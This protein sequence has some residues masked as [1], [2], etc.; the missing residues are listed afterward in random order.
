MADG[1]APRYRTSTKARDVLPATHTAPNDSSLKTPVRAG[2]SSKA[3]SYGTLTSS[4]QSRTAYG[5]SEDSHIPV[6]PENDKH[7]R[8]GRNDRTRR[9]N[10]QRSGA[11]AFLLQDGGGDLATGGRRSRATSHSKSKLQPLSPDQRQSHSSRDS[12]SK[13][14]SIDAS[15]KD[16]YPP[17]SRHS[18]THS[19][20]STTDSTKGEHSNESSPSNV[21][22]SL[23]ADSTQIIH[24][25]LNLSESRRMASR[26]SVSRANPPRLTPMPDSTRSNLKQH[27]Q[28]QRRASRTGSP[29]PKQGS[30]PRIPSGFKV[31][32]PHQSGVDG[33]NATSYRYHFS[34]STL[35]RAQKAK[36][37]LEL[38]ELYRQ[39]LEYLPPLKPGAGGASHT[40]PISDSPLSRTRTVIHDTGLG[41]TQKLG[42]PYDPLQYIRNRKVRARE[43]KV[44]DGEQLGFGDTEVVREW[45]NQL[46]HQN[47][48][49]GS[50]SSDQSFVMPPFARA[51]EAEEQTSS[52]VKAA[53]RVRRPRVDWFFDPCDMIA[54]AYWL[55]QDHHKHLIEDRAS[56]KIF[57]AIADSSRPGSQQ[58]NDI[59]PGSLISPTKFGERP[60]TSDHPGAHMDAADIIAGQV[61]SR[62]RA[63][64][65]LHDIRGLHHRH[66][67]SHS[68][69]DFLA[70]RDSLSEA[71]DSDS[72]GRRDK[73][74]KSR[75]LR[76]DTITSDAS[77]LL[78]KQMMNMVAQEEARET[79]GDLIEHPDEKSFD[80]AT[81]ENKQQSKV[82]SHSHSRENSIAGSSDAES[83][84]GTV[85]SRLGSSKPY[86]R[87]RASLEVPEDTRFGF[88][89]DVDTSAPTS[90]QLSA[91]GDQTAP[92]PLGLDQSAP[93]SRASSP[94]RNPLSKVKRKLRERGRDNGGESQS[95]AEDD[96]GQHTAL[97]ET[98]SPLDGQRSR[99]ESA[100]AR[101]KDDAVGLR[102]IFKGPRIDNV[103][104]GGVS[105]IGDIIW[106]KDVTSDSDS[107]SSSDSE[108]DVGPKERSSRPMLSRAGSKMSDVPP[109]AKHFYDAM[110]HFQPISE[111]ANKANG[112]THGQALAPPEL[113]RP[114]S[115]QSARWEQ[116]KPPRID[117][118]TATPSPSPSVAPSK[119]L[120]GSEVSESDSN[121]QSASDE[122]H[123][124]TH[125]LEESATR[126]SGISSGAVSTSHH[127]SITDRN[128]SPERTRL[129]KREVARLRALIL[130]S[131]VKAME[132]N[133]RA[134]EVRKP[135]GQRSNP[136]TKPDPR[137][138]VCTLDW[139]EMIELNPE[140]GGLRE[141]AVATCEVYPLASRALGMSIQA[142][143]Q[144]WQ[145][146]ADEFANKTVPALRQRV[147]QLRSR[148][149]DDLSGL[150]RK[151][152][153]EAD[154]TNKGLALDQPLKVKHVLDAMD[155]LLRQRRR[156]FRWVRRGMWLAVEWVLIGFMWYVWFV[157]MIFRLFLGVGRVTLK[158]VRW[159]LWL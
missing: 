2:E 145:S 120:G 149:G 112:T 42:R 113:S 31:N 140:C 3:T 41:A 98:T 125:E 151:A 80:P 22:T 155:T 118:N 28:Q 134:N 150:T 72:D 60:G 36:D 19:T 111:T 101:A 153:D 69:N 26:R 158:G 50:Q 18:G 67:S 91:R 135:L 87:G 92:P 62:E 89:H 14:G 85:R 115:R 8:S 35:A 127:W 128:P 123:T 77:D 38:M 54:D 82:R 159:L 5:E 131:G 64:Q 109:N 51:D 44:I 55:E 122:K 20:P 114:P 13:T 23:D 124:T 75:P 93:P 148:L 1:D 16:D 34:E 106:R 88:H 57:P 17:S 47:S 79:L 52:D 143:G 94:T 53:A 4:D 138:D 142:S 116:L 137:Y 100:N 156:R 74:M 68:Y 126:G 132:I 66:N 25:A 65:K 39:L 105:K 108:S 107:D 73:W 133:R 90:P 147:W 78:Q 139:D 119:R 37:H 32:S 102:G 9:R 59:F 84:M 96:G 46:S 146:S 49:H 136:N 81:P 40:G 56:R 129:S 21:R 11:A 130:S 45:V 12:A 24:M 117:V 33:Q 152:A 15:H 86:Q 71:S 10:R 97:I 63:K 154:E 43:R 6:S 48:N 70:G 99:R 121:Q 76:R 144:R 7:E 103:I 157:V 30:S 29:K 141:Q 83:R 61:G 27:L 104:R 110:P 95:E 58:A